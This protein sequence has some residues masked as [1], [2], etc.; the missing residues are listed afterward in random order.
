[1][2][3]KMLYC[4][5]HN[6]PVIFRTSV[7]LGASWMPDLF[8]IAFGEMLKTTR[9]RRK[10][11]QR[12][13]AARVGVH[14]NTLWAWERGDYLPATRSLVLELARELHL[15][16]AETRQFLEA[17]LTAL[18]PYWTVPFPRNP[19][20]TGREALLASLHHCLSAEQPI[21]LM[22]SHALCGLGGIGKTQIAI[23]YAYRHALDYRAVFWLAAETPEML[24][25]SFQ[26]IAELLNL[27][28]HQQTQQQIVTAIQR[29]LTSHRDWLL[30]VDNVEDLDLLQA[31][32]PSA[33]QG[34]ILLTTRQQAL[35]ALAEAL[36]VPPFSREEGM[37]LLFK[38]GRVL[39]STG[40]TAPLPAEEAAAQTLVT[41]LEGLPLALDQAGAYIE[42]TSC[43]VEGYLNR[44][45]D[46][47]SRLLARRGPDRGEHP[48]SVTA[49]LRLAIQQVEHLHPAAAD[50]LCFCAFLYP[51]AIPE[52]LL[53]TDA[54]NLDQ[55]LGPIATDAVERDLALAVLR[56][57]SLITRYPETHTL[58]LHRLVQAV[59][60][61][62]LDR[63]TRRRWS[64]RVICAINAA[65]PG[66][67][68]LFQDQF[69]NWQHCERYLPHA[70]ACVP[71]LAEVE[72]CRPEIVDLFFKVAY[73]LFERGRYPEAEQL[74]AQAAALREQLHGPDHP[75][76][77]PL[78]L[79]YAA[80]SWRQ[81]NRSFAERL[82]RRAL[83]LCEQYLGPDHDETA[84]TLNELT[85]V[86]WQQGDYVQAERFCQR[87][88]IIRERRW[89]PDHPE[90]A[91]SL[92]NLANVYCGQERYD[93]AELFFKRALSIWEMHFEPGH[94]R[95]AA[96]LDRLADLFLKQQRYD[97]AEESARLALT[98]RE[99]GMG[100][101]HP[102]VGLSL[103]MLAQVYAAQ[104]K[105]AQ[106]EHLAR[107]ALSI[108]EEQLGPNHP[109]TARCL[110]LLATLSC[111]QNQEEAEFLYQR[112]LAIYKRHV[113]PAPPELAIALHD[114]AQFYQVQG[115]PE[116]ARLL[117]QQAR[118]IREQQLG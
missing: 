99:E 59:L 110:H 3:T 73:Y 32:L 18:T 113:H 89:G 29:W 2:P 37:A 93:E 40:R 97:Q 75:G 7:S 112:A 68:T 13:L 16:E 80:L 22:Q 31:V 61:D 20:F 39:P 44:Y 55:M 58:S 72:T 35:G 48:R 46:S 21:A 63:A 101:N 8:Q 111:E 107:R 23:E 10:L 106:A 87:A 115:R 85:V 6:S 54:L 43:G 71:L 84:R 53:A 86:C 95:I 5:Y 1:M 66:G 24:L 81:G 98:I 47:R 41:L 11:T 77:V 102:A 19:C 38:R 118:A 65:F 109:H 62:H 26:R 36:E 82:L 116:Q 105:P 30:I 76:H 117:Y 96:V 27:P 50:L 83:A 108:C 90:T 100:P 52:E 45:T 67:Y 28:E 104:N 14:V 51:E 49:T 78:L 56:R 9:K 33:R 34:A 92:T 15:G 17:S 103:K 64:E 91:D 60:R 70:L 79:L 74:V 69:A 57:F 25:A 88:L 94:P 114:L 12:Q 4:G 42:E